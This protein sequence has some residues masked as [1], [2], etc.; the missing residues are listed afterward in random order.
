MIEIR[1]RRLVASGSNSVP[2]WMIQHNNSVSK[3]QMLV[4]M[5]C[6]PRRSLGVSCWQVEAVVQ[7]PTSPQLRNMKQDGMRSDLI[8]RVF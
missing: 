5:M 3:L 2:E 1:D 8:E 7:T 4:S 6:P